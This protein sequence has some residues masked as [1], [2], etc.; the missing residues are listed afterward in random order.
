VAQ[1]TGILA[2]NKQLI[3]RLS[4]WFNPVSWFYQPQTRTHS[5]NLNLDCYYFILNTQT[6]YSH[7]IQL[8]YATCKNRLLPVY[9]PLFFWQTFFDSIVI[10]DGKLS[11]SMN[12]QARYLL[13]FL[14]FVLLFFSPKAPT[15]GT[16][17]ISGTTDTAAVRGIVPNLAKLADVIRFQHNGQSESQPY[18]IDTG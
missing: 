7:Q 14:A 11:A 10:E 12:A 13:P 9:A 16:I 1:N 3:R 17:A 4:E 15:V 5:L 6:P 8:D 2:F 18:T